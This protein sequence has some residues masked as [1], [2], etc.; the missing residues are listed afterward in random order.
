MNTFFQHKR[1]HKYTWYR[2][3]V[4][5]R[6]LIDFCIVSADL[7]SSVVDVRVKRGAELSTDHHLVVYTLRNLSPTKPRK[8]FRARKAHR[9][10]WELLADTKVRSVFASMI[11]S[12]FRELP[13]HTEDI[14]TEWNLFRSAV[15]TSAATSC[16]YKRVGGAKGS[17]KRTAWWNQEVKETIR[18]KKAA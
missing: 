4:G 12:L 8:P 11:A 16:G 15:T 13:D 17:E 9:I 14:E 18:A 2:D 5:Q 10:Q 6:S 1:I 7:F 3:S